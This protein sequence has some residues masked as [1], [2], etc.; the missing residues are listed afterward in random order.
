[1]SLPEFSVRQVVLV[2]VLFVVCLLGGLTAYLRTP[3]DFFPEIAFNTAIITARWSGASA[4]EIE[5]LV[6]TRI[7]DEIG[8]I[9]GIDELRSVS[10]ADESTVMVVFDENLSDAEYESGINDLRAALDRVDDLPDEADEPVIRELDT[11]T[12]WSDMRVAVV[13]VGG[14]GETP[15]RQVAA[16]V[17]KRLEDVAGVKA[18]SIRGNHDREIWVLVDRDVAA[19]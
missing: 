13:D 4:E 16:D 18:V 19:R 10:R 17:D 2:N 9:D 6:T 14:L 11:K 8:D 5:R 7:E 15:L 12:V 3:V 1:M